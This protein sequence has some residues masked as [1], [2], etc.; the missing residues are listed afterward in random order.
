[1]RESIR[2]LGYARRYWFLLIVSVF[3]MAIFGAMTAARA[4]LIKA[5]LARVLSAAADTT[6]EPLFV[7]PGLHKALYL[8]QFFPPLIHNIFTIVAIS[9]LVVFA[10][11]RPLRLPG[12]LSDELRRVL[13]GNGSAQSG[14]RQGSAARRGVL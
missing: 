7:V 6:P 14:I 8:E 12:R 1:M 9:I 5:V 11:A 2:L 4:L 10:D 3:L 13:G